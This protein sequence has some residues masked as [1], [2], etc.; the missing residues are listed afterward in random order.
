MRHL[1]LIFFSIL[2]IADYPL[3]AQHS[4]KVLI[5]N[6]YLQGDMRKWE[7]VIVSIE[8]QKPNSTNEKLELISYYYG[9][10]GY[11][12]G[13]KNYN[14]AA[15]YVDKGDKLIADVLKHSPQNATAYAFRGSFIG[16]RIGMSKFKAITLGPESNKNLTKAFEIEPTNI[17]AHVDKANAL[18]HTPGLFGGDKK[19]SLKLFL[20]ASTMLEKSKLTENNWFY[21]NVL[22]LT[23]KNYEALE[24]WQNAKG[25][26]EKIL[27]FSPDYK[28]VKNEL[29][30]SL[31]KKL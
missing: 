22:T 15:H 13:V 7:S 4:N 24:Q 10:I 28:W 27:R 30:P 9:Q 23:A 2:L 8:K 6:A 26:Y 3:F 11:L 5:Y 1:L 14:Q 19:Q 21:L 18:Y 16:F 20:K 31:L 25:M 29:Y 12:L 17:Q